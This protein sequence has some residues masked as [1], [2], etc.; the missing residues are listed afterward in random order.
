MKPAKRVLT[1]AL[2]GLAAATAGC[3]VGTTSQDSI[4]SINRAIDYDARMMVDD[5]GLLF[6]VERVHRGSRWHIR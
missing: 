6:Q 2:L 1:I 5:V 4:R 3:G